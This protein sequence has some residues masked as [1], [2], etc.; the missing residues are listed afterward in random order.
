[1]A[2]PHQQMIKHITWLLNVKEEE[3]HR[4]FP[5]VRSLLPIDR[6]SPT[7]AAVLTPDAYMSSPTLFYPGTEFEQYN[8][9][10]VPNSPPIPSPEPLPVPPPHFHNS[11]SITPPVTSTASSTY[12]SPVEVGFI[13]SIPSHSPSPI[14]PMA[15]ILYQC[16]ET[17]DIELKAIDADAQGQ[18]PSPNGPQ[19]GILPGPGWRDNFTETGTRHFFIIPNGKEDIIAP[20]ISYNL[21]ATFPEL[22]ATNRQGCMVHSCP[23]HTHPVRQY[24]TAISPKDELLLTKKMQFTDL[25]DWALRKEDDPMLI[26]EVQ[27]FCAHH[28]KA[29]QIACCIGI[30]KESLQ[31]ERLAMYRSS[32]CLAT[33]N[34]IACICHRIDHDMHQAPY[35]KGK[36][37]CR[38][39]VAIRDHA[40]HAWGKD[41]SKM[42]DWC[43]KTGHNIEECYSLGYCQHCLQCSH[44]GTD[45][46]CPHN[47]C[48]KFEDCKVYPSHPNFECGHCTAVDND[49]D[50]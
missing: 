49:I 42:C 43:S 15:M 18:T 12:A 9:P 16:A 48:N 45:C 4:Q 3:V 50:V 23:L 20:F 24:H 44:N 35:F 2:F 37:G 13:E 25:V 34:A 40:I 1:M 6:S 17:K 28:S 5:T 41:N 8:K 31:T 10:N 27:Y 32:E 7:P 46:L 29:T 33:T 36:R 30:L 11:V 38:A 21:C 26:G 39:Q 19:P 22:L 14:S 47:L